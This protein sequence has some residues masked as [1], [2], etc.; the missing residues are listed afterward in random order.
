MTA[1]ARSSTRE[2]A[3]GPHQRLH[4]AYPATLLVVIDV[5][6][7]QTLLANEGLHGIGAGLNVS[8]LMP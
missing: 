3:P 1:A 2:A 8:I 5:E 7:E 6:R 4:L